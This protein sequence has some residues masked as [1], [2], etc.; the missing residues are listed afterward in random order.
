MMPAWLQQLEM[1]SLGKCTPS[2]GAGRVKTRTGQGIW[3]SNGNCGQHSFYQWLREG[4]W[5][6]SINLV[7]IEDAGH[8][9]EKMARVLNA[10]A[11]AQAEALVTRETEEFFN[12]LLLITLKNFSTEILGSLLALYEHKT[13]FFGRLAKI[14][15]FDQPGVEYAKKLART[16]EG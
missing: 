7:K 16:L 3:G 11:D 1:E 5:C 10:N 15:P 14:N 2:C 9:H 8:A 4:T 12:S 13:A 6:T